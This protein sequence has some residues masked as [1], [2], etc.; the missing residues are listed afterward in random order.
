VNHAWSSTPSTA[1]HGSGTVRNAGAQPVGDI[2]LASPPVDE[3]RRLVAACPS[4]EVA[5]LAEKAYQPGASMGGAFSSLLRALLRNF[6][7]LFVDPMA[8]AF[9]ELA[10]PAIRAALDIAPGL[11]ARLA[12]RN[13]DLLAVG[14]HAQSARGGTRRWSFCPRTDSG[15]GCSVMDAITR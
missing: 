1:R 9:R 6:D 7:I 14:Y 2:H 8:P 3:L 11:S 5:D 13:R 10:A 4:E 15:S 12:E